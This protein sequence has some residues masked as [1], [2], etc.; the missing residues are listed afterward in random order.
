MN[1]NEL[2]VSRMWEK[3]TNAQIMRELNISN[4]QLKAIKKK[5]KL[6]DKKASGAGRSVIEWTAEQD[7]MVRRYYGKSDISVIASKVSRTQQAVYRR[8]V[9]LGLTSKKIPW[10]MKDDDFLLKRRDNY[11]DTFSLIEEG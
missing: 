2:L 7:R 6:P 4:T 11:G 5:L 8:A 1:D 10:S 9:A 3:N